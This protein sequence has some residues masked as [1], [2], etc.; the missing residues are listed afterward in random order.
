MITI[1]ILNAEIAKLTHLTSGT[2]GRDWRTGRPFVAAG[3]GD[4]FGALVSALKALRVARADLEN[5]QT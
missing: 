1:T 4:E 2:V 3:K 5:S